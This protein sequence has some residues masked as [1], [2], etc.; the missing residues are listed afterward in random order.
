MSIKERKDGQGGGK[1]T[2]GGFGSRLGGQSLLVSSA[3]V[4]ARAEVVFE[5]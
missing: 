3:K 2:F 4:K 5:R 1:E